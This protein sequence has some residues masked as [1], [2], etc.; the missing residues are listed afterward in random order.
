LELTLHP[1]DKGYS[2]SQYYDCTAEIDA[3]QQDRVRDQWH[4]R[5]DVVRWSV[6]FRTLEGATLV[7]PV[8]AGALGLSRRRT[9]RRR[10]SR[11]LCPTCGYD[12]R[13]GTGRCPECGSESVRSH[14]NSTQTSDEAV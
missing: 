1:K 12:L 11:G 6:R 2:G 13:A 3:S 5:L 14:L 8:I 9:V 4:R 10:R 7:L